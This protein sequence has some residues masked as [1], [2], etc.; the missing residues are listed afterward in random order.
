MASALFGL[1]GRTMA[2]G[3]AAP[4]APTVVDAASPARAAAAGPACGG[5]QRTEHQARKRPLLPAGV[6][7]AAHGADDS[8][9]GGGDS[10]G[11]PCG[12]EHGTDAA[13][14]APV[15]SSGGD[16]GA[17]SEAAPCEVAC[18]SEAEN[19]PETSHGRDRPKIKRTTAAKAARNKKSKA[20]KQTKAAAAPDAAPDAVPGT[21]SLAAEL[22]AEKRRT[23]Q[24]EQAVQREHKLLQLSRRSKRRD[25]KTARQ[26]GQ[27][28]ARRDAKQSKAQKRKRGAKLAR[29]VAGAARRERERERKGKRPAGDALH[30][31]ERK[32]QRLVHQGA[33]Q[34]ADNLLNSIAR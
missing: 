32:H 27:Q 23:A 12:S 17:P 4:P 11:A 20:R 18:S 29:A 25:A 14:G 16:G 2:G 15:E 30:S 19:T 6:P 24:L 10:G 5:E 3:S 34:S 21:G 26:R 9:R 33:R 8:D 28:E 13:V 7:D 1:F 22:A 31:G